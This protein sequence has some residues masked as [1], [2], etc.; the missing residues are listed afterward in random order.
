MTF[1]SSISIPYYSLVIK[2]GGSVVIWPDRRNEQIY[3][4]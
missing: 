3:S 1:E 4:G 2:R